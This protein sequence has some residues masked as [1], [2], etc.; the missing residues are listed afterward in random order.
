MSTRA[1]RVVEVTRADEP[2]FNV[3]HQSALLEYIGAEVSD[4]FIVVNVQSLK[5]LLHNEDAIKLFEL[6]EYDLNHIEADIL[7]AEQQGN[8]RIEYYCF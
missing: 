3:T 5:N 4:N 7:D 2:T 1:Y 8:G 6:D